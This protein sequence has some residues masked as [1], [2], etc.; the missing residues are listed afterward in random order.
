MK[1]FSDFSISYRRGSLSMARASSLKADEFERP[2]RATK[3]HNKTRKDQD[4]ETR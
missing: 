1:Y 4:H 2:T 3:D